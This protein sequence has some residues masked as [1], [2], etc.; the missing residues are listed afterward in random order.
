MGAVSQFDAAVMELDY[1]LSVD[2]S[3]VGEP[4]HF[5]RTDAIDLAH[6]ISYI[7]NHP[8]SVTIFWD[9]ALLDVPPD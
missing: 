5:H 7:K 6:S 4:P 2:G 9:L 3:H 1:S 8:A